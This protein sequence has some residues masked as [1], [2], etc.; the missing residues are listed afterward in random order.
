MS[1][2]GTP[3]G[4]LPLGHDAGASTVQV[5]D[6]HGETTAGAN[7]EGNPL[8]VGRPTWLGAVA[9]SRGDKPTRSATRGDAV[10]LGPSPFIGGIQDFRTVGRPGGTRLRTPRVGQPARAPAEAHDV[11]LGIAI[12]AHGAC[13]LLAV[14]REA[15]PGVGP[16]KLHQPDTRTGGEIDEVDVGVAGLVSRVGDAAT[17][18]AQRRGDAQGIVMGD[19]TT[20]GTVIVGKIDLLAAT[21]VADKSERRGG[22]PLV[23]GQG[24]DDVIH[25]T[26]SRK[27]GTPGIALGKNGLSSFQNLALKDSTGSRSAD[28]EGGST[29]LHKREPAGKGK[30]IPDHLGN[31]RTLAATDRRE[32]DIQSITLAHRD[33]RGLGGTK[34]GCG[35]GEDEK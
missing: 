10:K 17:I 9:E 32:G 33:G 26:V 27:S 29:R 22:D 2:I 30:V 23:T 6:G 19:L 8:T 16:G 21:A 13:K 35:H 12:L 24:L 18:G 1:G 15:G 31:G 20:I 5:H 7:I 25:K 11:E 34:R 28:G 14:G 3:D 4:V